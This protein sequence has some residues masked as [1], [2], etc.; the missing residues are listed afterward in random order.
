MS[1]GRLINYLYLDP[2]SMLWMLIIAATIGTAFIFF[3]Q[4]MIH[5]GVGK[6][7]TDLATSICGRVRG[8][9]AKTA[10]VG[11]SLVGTITGAPMS[12]V[13]LTG[14]I[15]IP[16]MKESG[17]P[18]RM[19]GAVEAVA[20]AGGQIMPPVMGIAAFIIAENLG[21]SYA[22]VASVET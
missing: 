8:G 9:S 15:T 11:S 7:L 13:F 14:S 20:S 22:K 17:Y 4:A 1:F 18:S 5:F 3:G 2:N 12:N 10:V 21:V 6:I 19:A 16:M